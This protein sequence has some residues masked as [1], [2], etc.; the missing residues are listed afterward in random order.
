M[1]KKLATYAFV[2]FL[3]FFVTYSP[4]NAAAIARRVGGALAGMATGFGDFMGRLVQ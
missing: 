3:I 1:V 2:A 4:A